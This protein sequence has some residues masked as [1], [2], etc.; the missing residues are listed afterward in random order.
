MGWVKG[1]ARTSSKLDW[2]TVPRKVRDVP[3][4]PV[5]GSR[6]NFHTERKPAETSTDP[7]FVSLGDVLNKHDN[8]AKGTQPSA[9]AL[10]KQRRMA[11]WEARHGRR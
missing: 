3:E 2:S 7:R 10:A 11:E 6:D 5:L 9:K 4:G 1:Q 8:R